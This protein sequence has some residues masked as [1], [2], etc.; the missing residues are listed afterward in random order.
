[1]ELPAADYHHPRAP[2]HTNWIC[3][4]AWVPLLSRNSESILE[5]LSRHFFH[6]RLEGPKGFK[7]IAKRHFE[8][9][10]SWVTPFGESHSGLLL[11]LFSTPSRAARGD[12]GRFHAWLGTCL[13]LLF[14]VPNH[15]PKMQVVLPCAEVLNAHLWTFQHI[16]FGL[17]VLGRL[18]C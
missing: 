1:M 10:Q 2:L 17:L 18:W 3:R 7:A 16:S 14:T 15:D 4:I 12:Q 11:I 6:E 9:S 5:L 13:G 8:R